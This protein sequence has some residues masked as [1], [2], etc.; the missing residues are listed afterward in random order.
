VWKEV[1]QSHIL[2]K[3]ALQFATVD[4][5]PKDYFAENKVIFGRVERVI[6]GDTIRIRHCPTRFSCPQPDPS[7]R[8]IYDSTL[9]IRI[10]GVDCPELQKRKSDPP[11]Q[12]F[13]EEAKEFASHLILDQKVKVTLLRKDRYGR[14]LGKVQTQ[15]QKFPPLS[16]KDLSMELIQRGLATLYTGGGAEYDGNRELLEKKQK[17]AEKKKRGV[18][19]QGKEMVTPAEFKR[20]QRQGTVK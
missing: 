16:R 9:S 3:R 19:S 13:A 5:I 7:V 1:F 4:D 12:P 18:W 10:Y 6:D 15:L 17:K 2:T 8:R 14:A 20:R 11:S